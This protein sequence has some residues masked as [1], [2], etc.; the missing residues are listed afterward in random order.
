MEKVYEEVGLWA[1]RSKWQEEIIVGGERR[2][3]EEG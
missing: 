2:R 1:E 3:K